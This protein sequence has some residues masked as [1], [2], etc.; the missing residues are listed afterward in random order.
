MTTDPGLTE[1]Y[2]TFLMEAQDI[3]KRIEHDLLSLR[4]DRSPNRVHELLR[5][6]HTLKG[7][8]ASVELDIIKQI[9]HVLEDIFKV[10]YNPDVVVDADVESF[11]LEGYECLRLAVMAEITDGQLNGQEVLNRMT[12]IVVKLQKKLGDQ[13]DREM[14]LPTSVELGFDVVQSLF[15]TAVEQRLQEL[16]QTLNRGIVSEVA[17]EVWA[18]ADM[19]LGLAESVNLPGFAAIAQTVLAALE[20][21]PDQAITIA[22]LALDDFSQAQQRVLAGDRTEGGSPSTAW[23]ALVTPVNPISVSNPEAAANE[24]ST[25]SNAALPSLDDLFGEANSEAWE[26]LGSATSPFELPPKTVV[27]SDEQPVTTTAAYSVSAPSASVEATNAGSHAPVRVD[28]KQLK[29]LDHLAGELL[30]H[31]SQQTTQ[32]QQLRSVIQE[33]QAIVQQHQQT[34]YQLHDGIERLLEQIEWNKG[35]LST[36]LSSAIDS[37]SQTSLLPSTLT[38][39]FDA[40]EMERYNEVRLLLRSA[41]NETVQLDEITETVDQ[42][43]KESRRTLERQRRVLKQVREDLTTL[44]MHPL[45]NLFNRFPRLLQ[46]LTDSHSK[47]VELVLSGTHVLVDKVVAEKLYDPLLHLI[48]NAFDHGIEAPEVRHTQG[49]PAVGRIEIRATQQGNQ[50]IIDVKDDGQGINLQRIAQQAID[51]NLLTPEQVNNI[52]ESQLLD[53]LFQPGFSTAAQVNDLSGRGIGLD[54]VNNQLQSM[55]G[56]IAISTAPQQ[57][58]TF[59]LK[60][61][62]SLTTTKLLVCQAEEFTYALPVERVEQIV[63]PLPEQLSI[64]VGEQLVLHWIHNNK[65]SIVPVYSLSQLVQYAQTSS[66]FYVTSHNQINFSLKSSISSQNHPNFI[67]KSNPILLLQTIYGYRGLRVDRVLGEQELVIRSLGAAIPPPPY[68]YG[69]CILSNS[70]PALAIDIEV[71]MQ[72]TTEVESLPEHVLPTGLTHSQFTLPSGNTLASRQPSGQGSSL[73]RGR[74]SR[75]LVVDDSLTLRHTLTVLLREAGCTVLQA[76]DGLEA[77]AQ[78]RQHT[79]INLVICDL[80]MPRLNG[81]EF[82]SRVQQDADLAAIPVVVLTS[83]NS[84][85]HRQ[86][87]L[88]LGAAAYFTKPYDRHELLST[89]ERL[90]HFSLHS[91]H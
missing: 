52:P 83:R 40:L 60:I 66:Q 17:S 29:Q 43:N 49:K 15:E 16:A 81:F 42:W 5:S 51:L 67:Q 30:I 39:K 7:A 75:V 86:I 84:A 24:A 31:Q 57:G 54:V 37:Y 36:T 88:T 53:V 76:E 72:L 58:T 27:A 89:I 13:F 85:K 38:T 77:L 35:G 11:L 50:T 33:M 91:T 26:T 25:T 55:N 8:S 19:F 3:L 44:R 61:P 32:E 64:L 65:E 14:A 62:L 87:A 56:S 48:R 73:L 20:A 28:V 78:L 47:P 90:L 18:K 21:H 59:T 6:A 23:Q 10:L 1:G 4:E 22:Q 68:I 79:D 2:A 41:V 82:L 12:T 70:R 45:R 80:E 63:V 46:Q 69:C 9:A 34:I 71:L 74:S